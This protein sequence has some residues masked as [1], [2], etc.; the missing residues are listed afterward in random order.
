TEMLVVEEMTRVDLVDRNRP[1][2]RVVVVPEMFV[3]PLWRPARI[4][5]REVVIR[6]RRLRLEG[7]RCPHARE[8]PPVELRGRRDGDLLPGRHGDHRLPLEKRRELGELF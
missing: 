7:T 5:V 6:A 3:L 4:D 8:R 2:G 1:Q